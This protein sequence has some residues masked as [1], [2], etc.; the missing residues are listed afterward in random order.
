VYT[1]YSNVPLNNQSN[2]TT[3][4]KLQP[5]FP[6]PR[7]F[8]SINQWVPTMRPSRYNILPPLF[9]SQWH[10]FCSFGVH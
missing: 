8:P 9:W 7:I 5:L 1:Y 6:G 3:I 10:V 4:R 2:N